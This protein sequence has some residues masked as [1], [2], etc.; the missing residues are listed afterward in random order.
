MDDFIT[1]GMVDEAT[2]GVV[3][4]ARTAE[5]VIRRVKEYQLPGGRMELKWKEKREVET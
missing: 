3:V 1:S 4:E 2:R 5:E